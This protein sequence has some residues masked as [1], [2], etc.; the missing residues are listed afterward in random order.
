MKAVI[1]KG[2]LIVVWVMG[3][4][5]LLFGGNETGLSEG[6]KSKQIAMNIRSK[7]GYLG[8]T[9]EIG[10]KNLTTQSLR[11]R[12]NAGQIF[13][14]KDTSVQDL[15]VTDTIWVEV[16]PGQAVYAAVPTMCT[17]SY[18][19]SPHKQE[20]FELGEMASGNLL[21]L[22]LCL[23]AHN[24]SSSTAQSAVWSI[25][26]QDPI[27]NIYGEN[28]KEMKILA[29]VLSEM[30]NVP[31]Q[32]FNTIPTPHRITDINA[33]L[34]WR[35]D[36]PI[37]DGT[38]EVR[39]ENGKLM[40]TYFTGRK[41]RSGF[42][43]HVFGFYHTDSDTTKHFFIRLLDKGQIIAEKEITPQDEEVRLDYYH[44]EKSF[45]FQVEKTETVKVILT[46]ERGELYMP[47]AEA[48]R[49]PEGFH[50][51]TFVMKKYLPK[52]KTYFIRIITDDNRVLQE[53]IVTT[54]DKPREKYAQITKKGEIS[55]SIE[56]QLQVVTLQIVSEEG[57]IMMVFYQKSRLA[58]GQ[59]RY[60]Y[61]FNHFNGPK[62]TFKVQLTDE[63][64]NILM[65]KPLNP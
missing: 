40:R 31:I 3:G 58:P 37:T 38:L 22:A 9:L 8:K 34:E 49:I 29:Q 2:W 16:P 18:N 24:I 36:F 60:S 11:T 7:G 21:S 46:D 65:E 26:N 50:H 62:A 41:Y 12:I 63:T 44:A 53:K 42:Q 61:H 15:I 4:Y 64:G 1:L 32:M 5:T 10:I 23:S 59:K 6:L 14:S 30:L 52:D 17:Q 56:K 51:K 39:D 48:M 28:P 54:Q 43:Q 19:R 55:F 20:A 45:Q 13:V 57:E 35:T 47:L 27:D 25:A 33:S